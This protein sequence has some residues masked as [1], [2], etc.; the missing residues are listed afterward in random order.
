VDRPGRLAGDRRGLKREGHIRLLGISVNGHQPDDAPP[1]VRTGV[2]GT[3]QVI[4]FLTC[5]LAAI[6]H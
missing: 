2:L 6:E 5:P 4:Y 3:V 1:L